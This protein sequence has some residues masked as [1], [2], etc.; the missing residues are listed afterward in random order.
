MSQTS[1]RSAVPSDS[2]RSHSTGSRPCSSYRG[3]PSGP[4]AAWTTLATSSPVTVSQSSASSLSRQLARTRAV[5]ARASRPTVGSAPSGPSPA[6]SGQ[7]G[8][9][10]AVS[11]PVRRSLAYLIG[12]SSS[13]E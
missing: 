4:V 10:G 12:A 8:A 2:S 5:N 7:P 9:A 1:I 13:M 6:N 3:C 11:G